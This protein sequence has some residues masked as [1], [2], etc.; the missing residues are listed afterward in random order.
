MEKT[1][2]DLKLHER[3]SF[4][5]KDEKGEMINR[6]DILRVPGGWIYSSIY[7]VN[8]FVPEGSEMAKNTQ[9]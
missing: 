8:V 2:Y 5:Q 7:S 3:M 9:P 4:E 1:P 6:W